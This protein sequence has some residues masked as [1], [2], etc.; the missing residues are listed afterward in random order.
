MEQEKE[1]HRRKNRCSL[2]RETNQDEGKTIAS[3]AAEQ[4][5]TA[6]SRC[7][8]SCEADCALGRLLRRNSF[9]SNQESAFEVSRARGVYQ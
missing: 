9:Y 7:Q 4:L 6:L 1:H 5:S 3:S 8:R 2:V